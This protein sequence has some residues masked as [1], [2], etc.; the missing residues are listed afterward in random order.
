MHRNEVVLIGRLSMEPVD[1][2][3]PSGGTL[4][5]WRLAV[6]RPEDQ[7][8][9]QRADAIECATFE[10]DVRDMTAGWRIDDVIEVAGALRRR[11]WRG[12]SRHE[13]E[14]RT[15]RRLEPATPEEPPAP[16]TDTA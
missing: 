12:G 9:R 6:R 4:T 5:G 2:E 16:A 8:G 10:D 1:R 3:L 11:W 15:A 7:A 14:V 13:V